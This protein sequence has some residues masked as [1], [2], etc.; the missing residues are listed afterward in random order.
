MGIL[1]AGITDPILLSPPKR[2][3][4]TLNDANA[5]IVSHKEEKKVRGKGNMARCCCLKYPT[6]Q[7]CRNNE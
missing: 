7:K 4:A 1:L 3:S 6:R 2:A 5:I